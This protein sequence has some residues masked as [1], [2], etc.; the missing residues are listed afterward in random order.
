ESPS[1]RMPEMLEIGI[2][3][4]ADRQP[5]R[6]RRPGR[7]QTGTLRPIEHVADQVQERH[8]KDGRDRRDRGLSDYQAERRSSDDREPEVVHQSGMIEERPPE[9]KRPGGGEQLS[10]HP[11]V[12]SLWAALDS[13]QRLPPCEDGTLT[14]VSRLSPG[15]TLVFPHPDKSKDTK[16]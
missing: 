15:K 6:G 14:A 8:G 9:A 12:V 11:L 1:D 16:N 10:V 4:Q 3:P 5:E 13:N 2:P 7:P